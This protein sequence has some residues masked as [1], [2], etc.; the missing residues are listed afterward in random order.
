MT[1]APCAPWNGHEF[2]AKLPDGGVTVKNFVVA[3]ASKRG[4]TTWSAA[5]VDPRVTAIAPVVIDTLNVPTVFQTTT[6]RTVSGRARCGITW[7]WAS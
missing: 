3:G 7:T 1:K 5:A 6:E 2:L 4:W